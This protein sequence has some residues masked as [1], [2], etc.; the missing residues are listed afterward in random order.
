MSIEMNF[1]CAALI[2]ERFPF[3]QKVFTVFSGFLPYI[4]THWWHISCVFELACLSFIIFNSTELHAI[5]LLIYWNYKITSR[6]LALVYDEGEQNVKIIK[7]FFPCLIAVA[8][9]WSG[10]VRCETERGWIFEHQKC[11]L[12]PLENID[13]YIPNLH[14]YESWKVPENNVYAARV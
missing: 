2:R 1:Y 14:A 4:S 9:G 6:S 7:F 3:I 11:R 12:S 13:K 10:W 8:D 5:T